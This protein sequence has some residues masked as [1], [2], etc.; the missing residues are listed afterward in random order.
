MERELGHS[1]RADTAL[2]QRRQNHQRGR[3]KFLC[4]LQIRICLEKRVKKLKKSE[5]FGLP[6]KI[7]A[8]TKIYS[9]KADGICGN[10][11]ANVH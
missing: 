10:I 5:F 1:G 6:R 11:C 3:Q 2:A 9:V 7:W 4:L 8:K